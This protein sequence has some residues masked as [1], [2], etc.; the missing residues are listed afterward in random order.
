MQNVQPRNDW[1]PDHVK[2]SDTSLRKRQ[3]TEQRNGRKQASQS[4]HWKQGTNGQEAPKKVPT[5]VSHLGNAK[6]SCD[7]RT[8]VCS[9]ARPRPALGDP[10][11]CSL[12]CSSVCGTLPGCSLPGSSVCGTLP[13]CSVPGSSVCGNLPGCSLPGSSVCGTLPG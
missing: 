8:P 9:G 5:L 13:G 4:S 10:M 6:E 12:P 1:Y 2:N 3:T 7:R 11:D